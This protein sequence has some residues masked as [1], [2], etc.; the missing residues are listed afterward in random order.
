MLV[1]AALAQPTPKLTSLSREWFTRGS[2]NSLTLRGENLQRATGIRVSGNPGVTVT[3][4]PSV[5][6]RAP[7]V[8]EASRG[9]ILA[10]TLGDFA[11]AT[12][13]IVVAADASL[14]GGELRLITETGV[15]NPLPISLSAVPEILE[16]RS[17]NE[18]QELPLP[19]GV[20]GTVGSPGEIDSYRFKGGKGEVLIFDVLAFRV[21]SPLDSSLAIVDVHGKELARSED[22]KGFDSFLHFKVPEDGEYLLQIRDFRYEGTAKHQYHLTAGALPCIDSAFPAGGQRGRSVNVKLHG[23]NLDGLQTLQLHPAADAPMGWQ[24]IRLL[25]KNGLSSPFP[26]QVSDLPESIETEPNNLAGEA[27]PLRVP[28]TVNGRIASAKDVDYFKF[29]APA[30]RTLIC[31]VTAQR[32]GSPLDSVLVLQDA[33]GKILARNDDAEGADARI[34]YAFEKEKEYLLAVR[35][36]LGRGGEDFVYRLSIRPS[37]PDFAVR[38]TPDTPR[39]HCGGKAVVRCE[40]LRRAGFNGPVRIVCDELPAGVTAEPILMA[41]DDPSNGLLILSASGQAEG[42]V[43]PIKITG[44]AA[45]DGQFL[46]RQ[47]EPMSGDRVTKE[48][49]LTVTASP[50]PFALQL[51]TLSLAMEQDQS[52]KLYVNV[53]RNGFDGEIK[54]IAEGYSSGREPLSRNVDAAAVTVKAGESQAVIALKARTDSETGTRPIYVRGEASVNG[55]G[56]TQYSDALPLSLRELP[57]TLVNTMKRL[58]VAVLPAGAKS[59]ASEAEFAVRVSRRGWFTDQINLSLEGLPEGVTAT[60]TNL[61]S[62]SSEAAF[63]LSSTDKAP[64]DKEFQITVIGSATVAG[65]SYQQRTAPVTLSIT[66]PTDLADTK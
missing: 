23:E 50:P 30:S 27:N 66:K 21:G 4:L 36:L 6:D 19:I 1:P 3:L 52:A 47:A 24:E 54:L 33:A 56:V 9:G 37:D 32:F 17:G 31:E 11:Q 55:E 13:Q 42:G 60:S 43:H 38:F 5:R 16:N 44:R 64:V 45:L 48:A 20:S 65:R 22:A 39:L 7:I 49:L 12:A 8:V 62:Q 61:P 40:I 63:R 57:F 15:S 35:D 28:V 18:P 2:T 14:R 53:R 26:F 25:T 51:A 10:E 46:T 58:S 59:A 34:D 41:P 29:K